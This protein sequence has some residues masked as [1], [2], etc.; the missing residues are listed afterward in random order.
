MNTKHSVCRFFA[1]VL[2]IAMVVQGWPIWELSRAYTWDL[3]PWIGD[4]FD[5]PGV[6]TASA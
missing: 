4:L 2:I 6:E 3:R 5:P 1:K